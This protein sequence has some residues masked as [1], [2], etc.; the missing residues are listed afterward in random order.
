M[1]TLPKPLIGLLL[2][3]VAFFAIWMVALKPHSS[4]NGG[5]QGGVGQYQSAINQA[6]GAV[7]TSNQANAKLGAPTATTSATTPS[8]TTPST[9][10]KSAATTPAAKA[11]AKPVTKTHAKAVTKTNAKAVPAPKP[12]AQSAKAVAATAVQTVGAAIRDHKVVAILFYNDAAADDRA[13]KSE[14]AAIP[15]HRRQ[16]VKVAVPVSQLIQFSSLTQTVDVNTAP[17]LVLIDHARQA[18]T[19][20]GYADGVEIAQRIDDALATK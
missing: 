17:E 5:S 12:A 7:T 2:G 16:V 19:L 13:M 15:T 4:S 3:T 1:G 18:S 8:A 9:A 20:A 10:T 14:L 11:A 6:H